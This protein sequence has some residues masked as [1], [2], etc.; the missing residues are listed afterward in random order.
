MAGQ[1]TR[2]ELKRDGYK[3]QGYETCRGPRCGKMMEI[4][5]KEGAK[6]LVMEPVGEFKSHFIDCPDREM[7]RRKK[8]A[9]PAPAKSG[10]LF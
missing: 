10:N 3:F 5:K 2:E 9:K 7:F 6:N 8:K 1:K 4:W